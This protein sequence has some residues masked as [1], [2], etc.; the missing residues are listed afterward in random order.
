VDS[1]QP[2]RPGLGRG[3]TH[4]EIAFVSNRKLID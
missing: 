4:S 3:L 2:M 1:I